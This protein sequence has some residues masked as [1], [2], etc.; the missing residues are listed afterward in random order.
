[1][2]RGRPLLDTLTSAIF[3]FLCPFL[4]NKKPRLA[5]RFSKTLPNYFSLVSL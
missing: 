1:M 4:G 2:F 5:P 3:Q